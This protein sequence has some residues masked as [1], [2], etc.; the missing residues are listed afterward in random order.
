MMIEM[1]EIL[2]KNGYMMMMAPM[3]PVKVATAV[4]V[5]GAGQAATVVAAVAV[6]KGPMTLGLTIAVV[7]DHIVL[8]MNI[9]LGQAHVDQEDQEGQKDQIPEWSSK[10]CSYIF[11]G[12]QISRGN[13]FR[14]CIEKIMG[15]SIIAIL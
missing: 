4:I 15:L 3:T 7:A 11:R 12:C 2:N 13:M 10:F 8:A 14:P 6:T 1:L 5:A 9:V